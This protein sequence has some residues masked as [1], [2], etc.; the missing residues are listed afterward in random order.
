MIHSNV[1]D[2]GIVVVRPGVERLTA[3]NAAEFKS[4]VCDLIDT[5][6]SLLVIDFDDVTFMDSSGLGVLVGILKKM[7]HRGDVFICGLGEDLEHMFKI[8]RMD[9][10]FVSYRDAATAIQAVNERP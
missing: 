9:R 1:V 4:A 10:V 5:G 6:A 2:G 3:V 8:S 7:G